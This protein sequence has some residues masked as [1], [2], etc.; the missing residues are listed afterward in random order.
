VTL[1]ETSQLVPVWAV[2]AAC[3]SGELLRVLPEVYVDSK[4]AT[5]TRPASTRPVSTRQANPC[6]ADRDPLARLTPELRYRAVAAYADGRG[7][8]SHT[9][10][11]ALWGLHQPVA[12]EP[13]RLS[14]PPGLGLRT[15]PGLVIHQRHGFTVEPPQVV[16]RQGLPV[17]RLETAVVDSWPVLAPE[18]RRDPVIRAVND[19]MTTP[20]RLVDA[21]DAAPK[22]RDRVELRSLLH[23]LTIGCR[24]PL[25][26]WG[27]DHVFTGPDMPSFDRQVRLTI[28][29]RTVYLDLYAER[30]KVNIELDG[31]ITHGDPRQREIDLRRDARLAVL[32]ILVV[33]FSHRRLVHEPAEVRREVLAVLAARRV[34]V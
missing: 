12:G 13:V 24:S 3:K 9:T 26:I 8:L 22:L 18:R 19:R 31:A 33:R 34:T 30:E 28:S 17:T 23:L 21:L 16:V 10:A 14:V 2:E 5:T 15:R 27:H 20:E 29:R 32:G 4:L 11:L 1:G 25:E 6:P 7:A